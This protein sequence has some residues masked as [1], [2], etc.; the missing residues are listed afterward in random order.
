[1]TTSYDDLWDEIDTQRAPATTTERHLPAFVYGTLRNGEGNYSW[2]LSGRTL[3]EQ[4]ATLSGARMW[5][6]GGFPFVSMKD[7][8]DNH[9][10]V[11]E[12]MY[13]PENLFADVLRDLDSLEGY[14]G[15]G[16]ASN[17]Y[18]REI[19]TVTTADGEQVEAYTYLVSE[20]IYTDRLRECDPSIVIGDGDWIAYI[21]ERRPR[22]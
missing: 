19:V 1:M 12:L 6:N 16:A 10:V 22:C 7:A 5:S 13:I 11:G 21:A 3:A 20:R 18:D 9:V 4:P 2:C 15:P 8:E 14:R 17:L